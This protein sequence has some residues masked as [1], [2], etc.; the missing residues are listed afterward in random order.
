MVSFKK[1]QEKNVE[2]RE[3]IKEIESKKEFQVNKL[4][5]ALKDV[6]KR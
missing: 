3:K 4:N 6:N 1:E 5:F 2:N